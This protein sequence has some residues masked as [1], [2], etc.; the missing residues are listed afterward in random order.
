MIEVIQQKNQTDRLFNWFP[1][2]DTHC[3]RQTEGSGSEASRRAL[4]EAHCR[5]H[6][7]TDKFNR[8]TVHFTRGY[9]HSPRRAWY[10]CCGAPG[11]APDWAHWTPR[12]R[13]RRRRPPRC[14]RR[15]RTC[16]AARLL[17]LCAPAHAPPHRRWAWAK[18]RTRA[19][20]P[21]PSKESSWWPRA[22]ALVRIQS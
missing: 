19:T 15:C 5:H 2:A 17:W 9:I 1:Q 4:K 18:G 11:Y 7:Q 14:H 3:A 16:D 12:V 10:N 20:A 21:D 13:P 8:T 22:W 6:N